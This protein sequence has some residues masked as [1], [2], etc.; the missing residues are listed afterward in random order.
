[1]RRLV[2]RVVPLLLVVLTSAALAGCGGGG[3]S[4]DSCD[5]IVDETME[6]LQR[7]IDDVD[8]E[9]EE[10]TVQDFL[11][12][13][14]DLPSLQRFEEDA[15]AIDALALELGCTQSEISAAVDARVG[16]LTAETDLGRFIIDAIRTGGL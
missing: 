12:T 4:A 16:E 7:L 1:M 15:A 9:F 2:R 3:I 6:L 10:L 5:E 11:A 13:Q 8:A 14:G